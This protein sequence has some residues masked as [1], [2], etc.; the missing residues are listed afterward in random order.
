VRARRG[1]LQ[2][3]ASRRPSASGV[4]RA[5]RTREPRAL[6]RVAGSAG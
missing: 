4:S 2:E 1:R 5:G 3:R 6:S